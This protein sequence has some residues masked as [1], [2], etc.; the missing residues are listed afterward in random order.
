MNT[1]SRY[2]IDQLMRETVALH[3]AGNLQQAEAGYRSVLKLASK[4][5]DALHLLGVLLHQNGNHKG[6]AKL[7]SKA[8][9]QRPNDPLFHFN[10]GNTLK[11]AGKEKE[12]VFSFK[13]SLRLD[14]QQ[15]PA[16]V[17]LASQLYSLGQYDEALNALDKALSITP[18]DTIAL[19]QQGVAL[20]EK[21]Q[22]QAAVQ[23]FK[24]A[25]AISPD[26]SKV[27]IN[28]CNTL[29]KHFQLEDAEPYLNQLQ[30]LKLN[31]PEEYRG[32][33]LVYFLQNN[34]EKAN[35]QLEQ[36][37]AVNP[38]DPLL[39]TYQT[40]IL[41]AHGDNEQAG[42]VLEAIVMQH[43]DQSSAWYKLS[44]NQKVSIDT[45]LY[46]QLL[47]ALK[48]VAQ[49]HNPCQ[50]YFAAGNIFNDNQQ[51]Q[52][53]FDAYQKAN[54]LAALEHN[55]DEEQ[56]FAR[57][58]E[59]QK[60]F[61]APLTPLSAEKE[62]SVTP[63]LILAPPRSGTTLIEQILG[64]H[65][66]VSSRGENHALSSSFIQAYPSPPQEHDSNEQQ[67][68]QFQGFADRYINN[69]I[70]PT[71]SAPFVTDKSLENH[72]YLGLIASSM[73]HTKIIYCRRSPLDV[74]ISNYF[75]QF[76][77]PQMGFSSDLATIGRYINHYQ[78]IML[79]WI[80]QLPIEIHIVD[81]ATLIEQQKEQTSA[82]LNY[83]DLPWDDACM[84][85]HKR[86]NVVFTSSNIQVRQ[87]IY[88]KS[89]ERW[90]PYAKQ[91]KPLVD[92]LAESPLNQATVEHYYAVL[93][94][95]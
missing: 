19:N 49:S 82:L 58:T 32:L 43:P 55:Y 56:Y 65:P 67:I 10:F 46:K 39:K 23:S 45:P 87:T 8:I 88:N 18:N 31:T 12:A 80:E 37:L 50:L 90:I 74:A 57:V 5:A 48:K 78:N 95:L 68:K 73:P 2:H 62:P 52:P 75:I 91:L 36:G 3:Q 63:I 25:L 42:K 40:F 64:S 15:T 54:A 77:D 33:F 69:L 4:N 27:L 24:K 85:F 14:P 76:D 71:E 11:A 22:W 1:L 66:M 35:Q 83:C 61:P 84:A 79:H 47:L 53:A 13:R 81:Y 92:V 26:D 34:F 28:L 59:I 9:K 89:L 30:K 60:H 29:V 93:K 51:Y 6:A 16:W 7:I 41:S 70:T 72:R 86:K 20:L 38:D 21:H 44:T 17:N 94:K